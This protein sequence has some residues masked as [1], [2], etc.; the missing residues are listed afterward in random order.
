MKIFFAT[1]IHGSEICW[2]KFLNAATFYKADLVV[3]G[4]DVTGKVMVPITAYPGY[5]TVTVGGQQHRLE[6]QEEL[7]E[8]QRQI[9]NRG[10]Y[11]AIV[12]PDE[13]TELSQQEGAVD[14]RFC[15]EMVQSLDRWMDMADGKLRGGQT[16]CILN[17]GNDDIWE[18]DD[19]I[20][21]SP[22]VTFGE[23]KS[24]E[25]DGGFHL[26]S[27][28][29]TNPTPW[30]TFR[31]APEEELAAKIEAV[32]SKVP[33][34]ERTIFNFHAPPYGTGLDEAPALDDTLR[35]THGGAVMKAVGSTAVRDAISKYQPMLS[36]HGHIHESRGIKKMGRTLAI[37][38]GSVYGDGVLQGAV[39]ELNPK[40]AKVTRY[41]LVNG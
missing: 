36:V 13:L 40:K 10:S 1:D 24:V 8:I 34:M 12:T 14:R 18:I 23:G 31:E 28:G 20:E 3:L 15:A 33:D 26:V 7:A 6:T 2:R 21:A 22:C 35:P 27:M 5:W 38:P 41:L 9:R 11:P 30:D 16:P 32:A 39:L 25:L 4:G 37:N 19:I 29:W 17:G